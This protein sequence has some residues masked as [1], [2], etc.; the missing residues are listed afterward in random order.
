M[1]IAV[2]SMQSLTAVNRSGF[3]QLSKLSQVDLYIPRRLK[4]LG[5]RFKSNDDC[6]DK[7][8]RL[9][10]FELNVFSPLVYLSFDL[11]WKIFKTRN[12]VDCMVCDFEPGTFLALIL[13]IFCIK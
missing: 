3:H 4:L 9:I 12:E 1:R 11:L 2:I 8:Y 5:G 10:E 13:R 7:G 6:S